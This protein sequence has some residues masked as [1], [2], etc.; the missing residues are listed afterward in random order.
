LKGKKKVK[1]K[2]DA[3]SGRDSGCLIIALKTTHF[4]LT[5]YENTSFDYAN[6][7]SI[8]PYFYEKKN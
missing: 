5:S 1:P 3:S 8:L 2:A 4:L 6:F 7:K